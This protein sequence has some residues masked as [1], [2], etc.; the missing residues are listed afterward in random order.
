MLV[1]LGW[2]YQLGLHLWKN[3]IMEKNIQD[4]S[5]NGESIFGGEDSKFILKMLLIDF[6]RFPSEKNGNSYWKGR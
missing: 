5:L 3:D 2:S 1:Q 6:D 4:R